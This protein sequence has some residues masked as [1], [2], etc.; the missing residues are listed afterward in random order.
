[1]RFDGESL[2]MLPVKT[3]GVDQVELARIS[4]G[5]FHPNAAGLSMPAT[6]STCQLEAPDG[7]LRSGVW[8]SKAGTRD[9]VFSYDEWAYVLEGEAH[10]TANGVTQVLRAG[11][12]F[13]TPAGMCM[14][15]VVPEYVR[16]VWVHRRP[17]LRGRIVRKLRRMVAL[18]VTSSRRAL[19]LGAT[20]LAEPLGLL[21]PI[22]VPFVG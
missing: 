21:E 3:F 19:S 2:M 18:G 20:A 7:G 13:Y 1:L 15:W 16:K 14:T 12:V 9:Y 10:V 17:P 5:A 22:L 11:D 6:R 8:D 4:D